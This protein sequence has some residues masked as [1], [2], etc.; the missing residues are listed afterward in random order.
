MASVSPADIGPHL[1]IENRFWQAVKAALSTVLNADLSLAEEYRT[2]LASSPPYE[3]LLA[4]HDDALEV[5][6]MLA[7][8]SITNEIRC[9]YEEMQSHLLRERVSDPGQLP[10]T[11]FP[12]PPE[13][14]TELLSTFG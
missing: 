11:N 13:R 6:A 14:L 5:A 10:R 7:G 12:V 4:L 8:V 9:Q 1:D 2:K 3:R